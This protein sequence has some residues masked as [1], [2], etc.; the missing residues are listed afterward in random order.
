ME[1]GR[2]RRWL[3]WVVGVGGGGRGKWDSAAV[4]YR[5]VAGQ[6]LCPLPT[7]PCLV[8]TGQILVPYSVRGVLW[9]VVITKK[10]ASLSPSI[11]RWNR[12]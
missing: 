3:G 9:S 2:P 7:G 11:G 5:S 8:R 4:V 1:N 12:L 10:H 6:T